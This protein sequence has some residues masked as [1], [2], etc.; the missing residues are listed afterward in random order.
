MQKAVIIDL[1]GTLAH[2]SHAGLFKK[3]DGGV[4]WDTWAQATQ[5]ASPH[6]WC[7]NLV[8]M[9]ESAGYTIIFITARFIHMESITHTWLSKYVFSDYKL[10]MRPENDF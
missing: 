7:L 10:F 3:K 6:N 2:T 8:N 4:D 5:F 1:D 9:Y